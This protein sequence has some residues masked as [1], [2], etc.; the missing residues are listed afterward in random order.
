MNSPNFNQHI[1]E[2]RFYKNSKRF[3]NK[4]LPLIVQAWILE[5]H[6]GLYISELIISKKLGLHP[7]TIRRVTKKY[8]T[9]FNV[10]RVIIVKQSKINENETTKK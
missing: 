7:Y 5:L 9:P 2:I 1:R 8:K 10:E 3:Q 6:F 4:E